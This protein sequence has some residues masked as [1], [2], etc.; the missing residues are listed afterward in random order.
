MDSDY[1]ITD[2]YFIRFL[3]TASDGAIEIVSPPDA[4]TIE[5]VYRLPD[6]RDGK[7]IQIPV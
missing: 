4:D 5:I 6:G 3:R 2:R 1:I 7:A